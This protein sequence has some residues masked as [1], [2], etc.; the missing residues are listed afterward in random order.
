MIKRKNMTKEMSS[1]AHTP[2]KSS[3]FLL[4]VNYW[5]RKSGVKMWRDFDEKEIDA[6]FA[7]IRELG[8][9]T[10]RVFPL[11]DDFQPIYELPN[12]QNRPRGIGIRHDWNMT[13]VRN[14]EMVDVKMLERFDR[15]VELAGKHNLKLIVAL[16]TAWMSGTLFNPSWKGGR[17]LFSHPF[18]LKY[19]MLYCRAFARRYAG[20]PE[21]LA[22]EYGNE[23]NCTDE[24]DSPETA[25]VWL[26]ALAAELRLHDPQTPVASGM[27]GLVNIASEKHPWG[28]EDNADAVDLLTTHPYPPFTQGCFME[29]PT[30]LRANLHATVESRYLADLGHRPTLCEETGTLGNSSLSEPLTAAFLRMRLFSLFANRIEGCLWWCYSDFRCSGE[31]P[32]RDVQME[33]DGLGLTRTDGQPKPAALEMSKFRAVADRFGGRMPEPERKAAILASDLCDDWLSLY[34]CYILC[35]QAG[36]TP[37]FV[38]PDRDDLTPY[39]LILAPSLRGSMPVSVPAWQKAAEAVRRGSV[40]YVSGDGVSLSNMKELFGIS[41]MEKIPLPERHA[42]I[43]FKAGFQCGISADFRNRFHSFASEP[44]AWYPDGAPAMLKHRCGKGTAYYLSL[45]LEASLAKEPFA[46][47]RSEAWKLYSGLKEAAGLE[48]VVDY[49]DPQCER[50]W[51]PDQEGHGWLTVINHRREAVEAGLTSSRRILAVNRTAGEAEITGTRIRLE[52]LQ[53]A[54]FE[55]SLGA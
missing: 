26:H 27:H 12:A 41:E 5:P 16:L 8:M 6:E 10:V 45:P 54:I 32:Y 48:S 46:F 47:D 44:A 25:W 34:N 13:P 1:I 40:L 53:A 28:I 15:V 7:Q 22:W 11:W 50:C 18:M 17:N 51:N 20:R 38:R 36:I 49:P 39:P 24:C 55:V 2:F 19:Q 3:S 31:L 37:K 29:S 21:I 35:V 43:R 4:G 42:A 23:Q 9:D 33:N 14:P 30:D 52:P